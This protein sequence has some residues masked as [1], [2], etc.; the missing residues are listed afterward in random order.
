M[1]GRRRILIAVASVAVAGLLAGGGYLLYTQVTDAAHTDNF[2]SSAKAGWNE[3]ERRSETVADALAR[4]NSPDDLVNVAKSTSA[5]KDEL[6]KI[7]N[8]IDRATVPAGYGDLAE[9][10]I[11]AVEDLG[12]YMELVSKIAAMGKENVI[13]EN[14]GTLENRSRK[15]VSSVNGFLSGA[16]FLKVQIPGDIY[17]AGPEMLNAWAAANQANDEAESA[18]YDAASAFVKADIKDQDFNVIW[19]MLS[20]R[21]MNNFKAYKVAEQVVKDNWQRSWGSVK[22][23]SYYVSRSDIKMIDPNNAE[24]RVTMHYDDQRPKTDVITLVRENG[25]WKVDKYPFAGLE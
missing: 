10:Q 7:A 18:V 21:N 5:M 13:S 9:R 1:G 17:L 4:V 25:A 19:S 24:I 6:D 22:P 15:A 23:T 16:D 20:S 2:K 14:N 11:A 8:A 3:I 12:N